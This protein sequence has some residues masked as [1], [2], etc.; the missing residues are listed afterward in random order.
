MAYRI[1]FEKQDH[2]AYLS[3]IAACTLDDSWNPQVGSNRCLALTS[4][5]DGWS[6]EDPRLFSVKDSAYISYTD[7][8]RMALARLDSDFSVDDTWYCET[9]FKLQSVEKNWIFFAHKE[10]I[11]ALYNLQPHVVLSVDFDNERPFCSRQ[12]VTDWPFNWPYGTPR[13]GATPVL[14]GGYYWH[15]FHS[16]VESDNVRKYYAGVY[17]FESEPPFRPL[18]IRKE[19]ILTGSAENLPAGSPHQVVFPNGVLRGNSCWH[20]AFGRNDLDCCIAHIPDSE[21]ALSWL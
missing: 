4:Q 11:K 15:F 10:K 13:G 7:G 19:P 6:I 12:F 8:R 20:L 9:D 3:R 21:I 1:D 17:V 14:H 5:Y 18:A 16:H 2:L